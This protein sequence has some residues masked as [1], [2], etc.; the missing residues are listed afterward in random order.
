MIDP[1]ADKF[2]I[3]D[4]ILDD[5]FSAVPQLEVGSPGD[6]GAQ[7]AL[8]ALDVLGQ[9]LLPDGGESLPRDKV[10]AINKAVAKGT[11][12]ERLIVLGWMI[13]TRHLVISLP[14]NKFIAW[15]ANINDLLLSKGCRVKQQTLETMVGRLQ[16][17]ANIMVQGNHFLGRL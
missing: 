12:E 9:P 5:I 17:V 4:V 3:A 6:R 8:L 16:H 10:L 1:E 14:Y 2:G 11:P 13:D 15:T 7:A